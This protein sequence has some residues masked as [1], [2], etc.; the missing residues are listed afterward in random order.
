MMGIVRVVNDSPLVNK[1]IKSIESDFGVKIIA[2]YNPYPSQSNSKKVKPDEIVR[3]ELCLEYQGDYDAVK[4]FCSA[5][6]GLR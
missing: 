3:S 2:K 5:S 6:V 1:T 4:K